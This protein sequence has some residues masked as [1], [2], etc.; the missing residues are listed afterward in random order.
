MVAGAIAPQPRILPAPYLGN[1]V[2]VILD[3][4]GLAELPAGYGCLVDPAWALKPRDKARVERPIPYVRDS[5]YRHL[6]A[7]EQRTRQVTADVLA[8]L[9]K[10]RNWL[11]LTNRTSQGTR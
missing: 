4:G 3:A 6:A 2:A 1:P 10:D 8:A 9:G 7:D 5:F 11:V